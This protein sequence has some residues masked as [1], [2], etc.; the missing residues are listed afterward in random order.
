M[1]EG[2]WELSESGDSRA[3]HTLELLCPQKLG[4]QG[5][6]LAARAEGSVTVT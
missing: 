6:G 2:V 4:K 3:L 1:R 5:L